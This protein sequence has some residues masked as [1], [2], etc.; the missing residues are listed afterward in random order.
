M[1]ISISDQTKVDID[2]AR[3]RASFDVS[4]VRDY[5]YGGRKKWDDHAKLEEV[6]SK[7]P[8]FAKDAKD[9][10][11]RT[12]LYN[13]AIA[14]TTRLTE[15]QELCKWSPQETSDAMS[16]LSEVLPIHLHI[17]AFE[18]VLL[19][20]GSDYLLS[21]YKHLA[22]TKGIQGCYLQTELGHGTNVSR[23]E[24][25]A[26]YIPDTQEFEIHSP[27]LTS[28]KWW[29]GSLGKT[30]THGVVQAK[31][32]LSGGKDFGPHLFFVQLRSL[33]DHSVLP[34]ITIGDIGPKAVGGMAA[35]DNG[36]ARFDH[37]RIPRENMLSKFAQVSKD[38]QYVQP[39]HAK[40]SYGGMLYIRSSMV[41]TAGW[42][43]AKAATI[44]IRYATVRRQ[45]GEDREGLERQVISYPS[46][47]YR[48]LPILS[49][50]YV[51]IHLGRRV[52]HAFQEMSSRLSAGDASLLAEMHAIT[53]GLKVLTSTT[54]VH[55]LET[56]R[57]SMGGHGYSAFS[58]VGRLY[59]DYL[60]SVTYEGDNFVLDGQV[61]R[62]AAKSYKS[63]FAS[64]HPSALLLS[65]STIYLRLLLDHTPE[66]SP[67]NRTS[68]ND[69]AAIILLLERRAALMVQEFARNPDNPDASINQ[70]ISKAVTEA[71]VAAQV[72]QLIDELKSLQATE[73]QCIAELYRLYV[74]TTAEAALVDL[75]S[76][77]LIR[78]DGASDPT[79]DLRL[80]IN[81]LCTELLPNAIGFTDAFGFSDW[82]LDSALGVYDGRVYEALWNRAQ[83]E[84]LNQTE[85]TP[86]YEKFI[87]P[88]LSRGQRL[89]G[90]PISSKL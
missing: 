24:T 85:I 15:L 49:R 37:I 77:G 3:A 67:L 48:L 28:S 14:I 56:A 44:S 65:P 70:R 84:P 40:L 59:A 16:I 60:P 54:S 79:R 31:L 73:K 58:G 30:A 39:P 88:M 27:T 33:E 61:V 10:I 86:V 11:G 46:T 19:S 81:T 43:V 42:T 74:L 35:M 17:I 1:V 87:K 75:F 18:P 62:A 47:Y 22:N 82:N 80:A 13:R 52:T 72:G 45:G 51:F 53:C 26:A 36:F 76:V 50:A 55:D 32:I 64:D 21:M 23:L 78:K 4:V 5:L 7:D 8:A 63:L 57:R 9:F 68:W 90:Q 69:T 6:L 2:S 83:A 71:F 12:D 38:G 66:I 20:Q 34:G 89:A 41:T 29:I 25:T